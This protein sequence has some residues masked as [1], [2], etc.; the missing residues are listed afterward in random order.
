MEIFIEH[1]PKQPCHLVLLFHF[2]AEEMKAKKG[3][4]NPLWVHFFI[5]NQVKILATN[6]HTYLNIFLVLVG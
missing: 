6:Q 2:T 3:E 4:Y 1:L 5:L